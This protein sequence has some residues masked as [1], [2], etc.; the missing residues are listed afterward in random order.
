MFFKK[1]KVAGGAIRLCRV[2]MDRL[3]TYKQVAQDYFTRYY[4]VE[5]RFNCK[6][7]MLGDHAMRALL[8]NSP[9]SCLPGESLSVC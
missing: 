7:C 6:H 3:Y 1:K 5:D 2:K 8:F 4:L 9:L